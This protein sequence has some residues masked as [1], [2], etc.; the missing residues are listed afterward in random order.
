MK[1]AALILSFATAVLLPSAPPDTFPVAAD[2][3]ETLDLNVAALECKSGF[4]ET[5]TEIDRTVALYQ[6]AYHPICKEMDQ[7]NACVA[8]QAQ[9]ECVAPPDT[10]QY[11]LERRLRSAG[12]DT[13]WEVVGT[14]CLGRD[15]QLEI[16]GRQISGEMAARAFEELDWPAATLLIQ[17]RDGETLVNLDTIFHTDSTAPV[18]QSVELLGRDVTIE[19]TPQTFTWRWASDEDAEKGRA[20][21]ADTTELR[22]DHGGAAY[23]R[24]TITHRYTR[25]GVKVHPRLD[26]TY[27]G[28]YRVGDGPWQEIEPTRTITGTEQTLTVLE[29]RPTLVR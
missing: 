2:C 4:E 11:R 26:V 12:P 23:P 9:L 1:T 14:V 20:T 5:Q 28:R 13:E 16:D 17:P 24:H 27:A 25:A 22:T 10:F 3:G 21:P 6:Y 18:S 29:A 15:E 8:I 19:A 7:N